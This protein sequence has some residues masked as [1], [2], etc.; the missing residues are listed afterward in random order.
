MKK[1]I[2]SLKFRVMD[3][4]LAWVLEKLK[5]KSPTIYFGLLAAVWG[6]YGALMQINNVPGIELPAIFEQLLF[7]VAIV[8][9]ALGGSSTF[10]YLP[11]EVQKDIIEKKKKEGKEIIS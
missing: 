9:T 3:N 11:K 8:F 4:L 5:A 7:Y 1:L 6:A 10:D 2:E